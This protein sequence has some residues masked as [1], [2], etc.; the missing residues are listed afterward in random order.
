M[1]ILLISILFI[2]TQHIKDTTFTCKVVSIED[3]RVL[4]KCND[5]NKTELL[6][7]I[8]EYPAEWKTFTDD[9]ENAPIVEKEPEIGDIVKIKWI[10]IN[11]E[12]C[13]VRT[14]RNMIEYNK[15]HS[16]EP[17]PNILRTPPADCKLEDMKTKN[18]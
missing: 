3:K 12:S 13:K 18:N 5:Y 6:I 7:P 10:M 2:I 11:L 16:G 9:N 15:Y 1:T 14:R 17:V 4:L 8:E